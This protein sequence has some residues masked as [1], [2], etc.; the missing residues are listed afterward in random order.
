MGKKK[1]S[2]NNAG[3][4]KGIGRGGPS[5]PY[6]ERKQAMTRKDSKI[7]EGGRR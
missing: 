3:C 7:N 2:R 5:Y 1:I 6:L 4:K